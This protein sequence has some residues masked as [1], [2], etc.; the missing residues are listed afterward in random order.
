MY[1]CAR[2]SI[3]LFQFSQR[4]LSLSFP[5]PFSFILLFLHS[6]LLL[7]P[8]HFLF[9]SLFSPFTGHHIELNFLITSFICEVIFMFSV[10]HFKSKH[11]EH[12]TF[13]HYKIEIK[14]LFCFSLCGLWGISLGFCPWSTV[15]LPP[16]VGAAHVLWVTSDGNEG[17]NYFW[18]H[19]PHAHLEVNPNW[20][21]LVH[22]EKRA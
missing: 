2:L 6:V 19:T 18:A 14:L 7:F 21:L 13:L 5:H 16:L 17:L 3:H 20:S 1:L 11:V 9:S 15:S 12:F 4:S 22:Q 8:F 10:L